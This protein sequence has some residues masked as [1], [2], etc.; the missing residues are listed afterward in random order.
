M[1][2]FKVP[3]LNDYPAHRGNFIYSTASSDLAYLDGAGK[4]ILLKRDVQSAILALFKELE[5]KPHETTDS[6]R[7][8][9]AYTERIKRIFQ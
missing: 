7:L 5:A 2:L 3:M 1:T 6:L 8:W 9:I 4:I